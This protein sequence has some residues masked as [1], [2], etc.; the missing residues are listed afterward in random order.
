M[1]VVHDAA[2]SRVPWETL[3]LGGWCPALDNGLSRRYATADLVPARFDAQRREAHELGVLI[4]ANPTRDL[5]GADAER[6]R[7]AGILGGARRV[8]LTEIAGES[9]TRARVTREFE[10]GRYDVIH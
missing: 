1:S 6:E 3:N 4:I 8:R 5:P 10:S 9:A 2:G 7:I